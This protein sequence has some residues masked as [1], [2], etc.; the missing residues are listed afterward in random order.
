MWNSAHVWSKWNNIDKIFNLVSSI[1]QTSC[2]WT[3][4]SSTKIKYPP[5]ENWNNIWC[6]PYRKRSFLVLSVTIICVIQ[7]A[8]N[9]T[10]HYQL[11]WIHFPWS[12]IIR[13]LLHPMTLRNTG[14]LTLEQ[15]HFLVLFAM[16]LSLQKHVWRHTNSL[17]QQKSIFLHHL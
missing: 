8:V 16:K 2:Q 3:H 4:I 9:S 1:T 17:I 15:M 7:K 13:L 11:E 14:F 10:K 6:H 12:I 5:P